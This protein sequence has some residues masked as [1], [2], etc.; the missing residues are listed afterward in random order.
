[1]S[2]TKNVIISDV[3]NEKFCLFSVTS[4]IKIDNKKEELHYRKF[5]VLDF[6]A[7]ECKSHICIDTALTDKDC[8]IKALIL[9]C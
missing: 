4:K 3:R 7:T 9:Q 1:M 2:Y 6:F 5:D 8:A